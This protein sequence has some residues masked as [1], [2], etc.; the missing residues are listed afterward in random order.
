M[1]ATQGT[2]YVGQSPLRREDEDLLQ[3][4]GQFLDDLPEP[5]GVLYLGF[6]TSPY[7]HARIVSIDAS[8]ALQLNGVVAVLTGADAAALVRPMAT[9]FNHATY[10]SASRDVLARD[11]VRFV[12]EHVAVVVAETPYIAQDAIEVVSVTFEP[13]PS[14]SDAEAALQPGAPRVHDGIP[15]N[16]FLADEYSTAGFE[17]AFGA[18]EVILR[19]RFRIGRIGALPLEPRG[20]L[21]V[22]EH[23]HNVTLY[24]STQAP[25]FVRSALGHHLGLPETRFRVVAPQVGGGFGAKAQVYPEELLTAALAIK[26]QRAVKWVQD[27]REDLLTTVHARDHIYDMTVAAT[28]D[29]EILAVRIEM[30]S[31]AGAYSSYPF[32]CG[33]EALGGPRHLPGPYT[34]RHMAYRTRAVATNTAPT[35]AFRGVAAPGAFLA[36]EGMVDRL[37]RHLRM[38]PAALRLRNTIAPEQLPWR[39]AYGTR[40]DSGSFQQALKQALRMIGYDEFRRSLPA[41]RVVDGE[42]KGIGICHFTEGSGISSKAWRSR[43]LVG[44]PAIAGAQVRVEPNGKVSAF[45]SHASSGQ[46]HFTTFAQLVADTIGSRLED[47]T[48]VEG[49]TATVPFGSGTWASRGTVTG[50]GAIIRAA[51]KVSKKIRRIAANML[52]ADEADIVLRETR[53]EVIGVPGLNLSFE[54]IAQAAY[55]LSDD[56]LREGEEQGLEATAFYDPPP[57]TIGNAVHVA[58]VGVDAAAGTVRIEKYVAVHDS[59]RII[60]PMIVDGQ[61][62]GGIAQGIGGAL[63]EEMVYDDEGQLLTGNLLDYL[64]PTAMDLPDVEIKHLESPTP[65][66]EGGFKG[67]GEGGVIGG[68]PTIINAVADALSGIGANVNRVPLRPSYLASLIRDAKPR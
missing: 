44:V 37:A 3:G 42:Y 63:M 5:K 34:I 28:K 9:K 14:V 20:C 61:V 26:Y 32:S 17:T 18:G 62:Q 50:G 33:L 40:F 23:S 7:A 38:D 6:V 10:R 68:L 12:G 15:G 58:I 65:D 1:S 66:A 64:L 27:R 2:G 67:V 25:H 47:V 31:N 13:L 8:A 53:A 43:G 35:G 11:R 60:N 51:A 48:I 21:A 49:D 55:S 54:R 39:N 59:G 16:V 22:F 52:E 36:L 30:I 41:D 24:T 57:I 45:I 29:G 4:R 56:V 19:E 46:G